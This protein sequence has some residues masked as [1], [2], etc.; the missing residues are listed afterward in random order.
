MTE[1]MEIYLTRRI[2]EMKAQGADVHRIMEQLGSVCFGA[3]EVR[4]LRQLIEKVSQ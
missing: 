4:E 1:Q 3:R 2:K